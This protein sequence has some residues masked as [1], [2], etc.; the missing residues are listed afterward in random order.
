MLAFNR[1]S[2]YSRAAT[3]SATTPL[4]T[5]KVA[6]PRSRSATTVRIATL[7]HA[8]PSGPAHPTDPA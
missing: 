2:S 1:H 4:P 8:A 6:R 7:K 5:P 3:E